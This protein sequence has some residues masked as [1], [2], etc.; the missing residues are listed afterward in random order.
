MGQSAAQDPEGTTS[1]KV[2][3][4]IEI[5]EILFIYCRWQFVLWISGVV[6][7]IF[8]IKTTLIQCNLILQYY[9]LS[10]LSASSNHADCFLDY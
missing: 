7:A 5:L 6:L 2:Y 9:Y 4:S 10:C 8:M 3:W 1:P